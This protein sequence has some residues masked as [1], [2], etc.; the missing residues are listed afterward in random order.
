MKPAD[1][2]LAVTLGFLVQL[3]IAFFCFLGLIGLRFLRRGAA[4]WWTA[5]ATTALALLP[6]VAAAGLA[7]MAFRQILAAMALTGSG[8]IAA[9]A[10]G[11][12]ESLLSLLLGLGL[13]AAL[14]FVGL[15]TT[16][17]GSSR[18]EGRASGGGMALPLLAL[19]CV[20]LAAGL[21]V[22]VLGMTGEVL[23]GLRDPQAILA[24]WWAS[25]VGVAGLALALCALVL[26]TA[27]RAPRGAAT[28]GVKLVM[29]S[30]LSF[31]GL[32]ALGGSW[33]VYGRVQCLSRTAQTGLPCDAAPGALPQ[34]AGRA[35][36]DT[37]Q[38]Q[39]APEAEREPGNA[40]TMPVGVEG[41]VPGGVV[42]G[43][44]GGVLGEEK[45]P[46]RD[47]RPP[48]AVR[49]GGQIKEPKKLKSVLPVYPAIAKQARVQGIV[50]LECTIG[51]DG[52]VV[53]V[54]VLRGIPLLDHAAID[55]VKQWIYT[56]TLLNGVPV[57]VI[58]TV[59]VNFRL[60]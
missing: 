6:V 5:P 36:V 28:L 56:P 42:G 12:A 50:I 10:A 15:L 7:T 37:P 16:A 58:M 60:S 14:A 20:A 59:T 41:G 1:L 49:V 3:A 11:S 8:G 23:T 55:A 13:V 45:G 29:L 25:V 21:V 38:T 30:A 39:P 24:R 44:D 46:G 35:Q 57:P 47:Q 34:P 52:R 33:V 32:G 22:L 18:V 17:I 26:I 43:V 48:K 9:M 4:R 53:E 31:S 19:L 27:L 2:P 54:R 40:G 51:P